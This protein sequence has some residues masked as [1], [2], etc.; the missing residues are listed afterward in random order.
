MS[1]E[2]DDERPCCVDALP[3]G[4]ASGSSLDSIDGL[5]ASVRGLVGVGLV[6]VT[7]TR[8]GGGR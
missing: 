7:R 6:P 4:D 1:A 3:S 2:I 5:L 8:A